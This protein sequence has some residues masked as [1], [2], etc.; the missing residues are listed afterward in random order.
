M[1]TV[2]NHFTLLVSTESSP[3]SGTA[4]CTTW[5]YCKQHIYKAFLKYLIVATLFG[6]IAHLSC[7]IPT[8]VTLLLNIN[9]RNGIPPVPDWKRSRGYQTKPAAVGRW[10]WSFH[11]HPIPTCLRSVDR[12]QTSLVMCRSEWVVKILSWIVDKQETNIFFPTIQPLN[13]TK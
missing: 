5:I 4:L 7:D 13:L 6:Q 3:S 8:H 11:R 12:P 10:P 1:K 2:S 9:T